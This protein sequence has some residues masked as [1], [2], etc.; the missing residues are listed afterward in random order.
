MSGAVAG[1][2][3]M[4][5][6]GLVLL[7]S[8]A[9]AVA[10]VRL[11]RQRVLVQELPAV[12]GLARVDVLCIDKTGT[13]TEGKLA[14]EAVEPL[15]RRRRRRAAEV[16]LA[17]LAAADPSP[18]ATTLAIARTVRRTAELGRS[19]H[20]A[21]LQRAEVER[22]RRSTVDGAWVLG[23]AGRDAGLG[24]RSRRSVQR[25]GG[26]ALR[27]GQARRAPGARRR[28]RRRRTC[29]SDLEPAALVILARPPRPDAADTLR[30]FREQDVTVKVISGDDPR[31]VG[32]IA[33]ELGLARRR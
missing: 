33:R 11:A 17:A 14:V 27:R 16:A 21:V 23:R 13:L 19:V 7:T 18:N 15:D 31:T 6:E 32:A 29:R 8:L 24:R 20:R 9:F 22:R 10:V 2:V 12:E 5:P 26:G 30:Y 3:A 1:T 4:V 28:A 25:P